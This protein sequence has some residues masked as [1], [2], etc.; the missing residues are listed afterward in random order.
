M[1][2]TSRVRFVLR[3]HD[4]PHA[5]APAADRERDH[6]VTSWCGTSGIWWWWRADNFVGPGAPSGARAGHGRGE[7]RDCARESKRALGRAGEV[8]KPALLERERFIVQRSLSSN[9]FHALLAPSRGK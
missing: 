5:A 9:G 8:S 7:G 2:V 6:W 4:S 1:K 3:D